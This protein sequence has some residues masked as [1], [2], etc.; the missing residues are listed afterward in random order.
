MPKLDAF[1]ARISDLLEVALP[2]EGAGMVLR[3]PVLGLA[4]PAFTVWRRLHDEVEAELSRAGEFSAIPDI[5]AKIAEN[6]ARVAAIF[7]V[8]ERRSGGAIDAATMEGAA[9]VALWHLNQARRVIGAN[10]KPQDAA[11]AE[12]LLIWLLRQPGEA[13]EPREI[14]NRGPNPLRNSERRDNALKVLIE[15]H[16]VAEIK[17]DGATRLTVNPKARGAR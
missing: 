7:H 10:D 8:V 13:I 6:A 9:A 4:R 3:P 15:K 2:V 14:L 16:C 1:R 11:D 17:T 5:G 12:L